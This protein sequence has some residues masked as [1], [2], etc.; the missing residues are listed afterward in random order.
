GSPA[1]DT[2]TTEEDRLK[3][4]V[5]DWL[6]FDPAQRAE[7]LKQGNAIMRKFL[8][9]KKHEAAKEVFV[10]IP[11]DSI[12]EIY[13]QC[14]E[15]GMESPLPAEDD[16]AIREHLCIRAYLEAHE[17]FNEW[18]KH[19][20]SVPQKPALIPQPTFT[21]KVAHEHKEKKYEMDFGIW[22]GHLDALTADVK[23]K[24]YNVLLFVDGGWMVDVREDAKEDHERTHQ[25]VLLRKLCLPML[26]FLLHTILHSTGQY[27]ECLQLA[28]MV[29]SERHKLYLVFSKEELRKLLQKLRESSLMLLDQ[30]LDPLGYEIQL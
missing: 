1:L 24:M 20:N 21:E 16:N 30:G 10:K 29:S 27:Q 6:V 4:D 12:A 14:E 3:I 25:M 18:F 26:C 9:S 15:Q 7:A 2:G 5:I 23:E 19:M 11:Q 22:K 28:D 13:N 8:A 17:T